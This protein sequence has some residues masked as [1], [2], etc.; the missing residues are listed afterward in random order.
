M[1]NRVHS[2]LSGTQ[3]HK[4]LTDAFGGEARSAMRY[5]IFAN[6]AAQNGDPILADLLDNIARNETEHAELWMQYLGEIGNNI[7]NLES[8]IASEEYE[9]NIMYPE[10]A[11]TAKD[12]GFSEIAEKMKNAANAESGHLKLLGKYLEEMKDGSLYSGDDDTEWQCRN[13]GYTH[14]GNS[15]PERCPLCSYPQNRFSKV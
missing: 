9:T 11:K 8:L 1:N 12:E 4:N 5:L 2:A 15:A 10:Y 7:D 3:T 14:T 13:C 6:A